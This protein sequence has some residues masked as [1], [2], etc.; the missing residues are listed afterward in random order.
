MSDIPL[1]STLSITLKG[2][3]GPVHTVRFNSDGQYCLSGGQDRTVKL[4]SPESGACIKTYAGHG[5]EVLG[6]AIASDNSRFA[7]V[8]GDKQAHLWDVGSGRTIRRFIGHYQRVNCVDFNADA[9]VLITGS[10]DTTVK[11]WDCKSQNKAPIQTLDEAKDGIMS[12]V[13]RG[14]EI[15]TGSV[16]GNIRNYDIRFGQLKVDKV[17]Q[18]ITSVRYTG[19]GNCIL[20]STLDSTIRLFDKATGEMLNQYK[21]HKAKEYRIQSCLNNTDAYIISGSEDGSLY[22]WDLVEASLVNKIPAHSNV[23]TGIDYHPDQ[24]ILLSCGVDG[25]VKVWR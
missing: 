4:W 18:P 1:P 19:D 3:V 13:C 22:C 17:A 9:T 20:C 16:D 7:A 24:S 25:F 21:S 8:G 12:L 5:K 11:L 15:L 10:Q 23:V 2:H 6:I 14:W